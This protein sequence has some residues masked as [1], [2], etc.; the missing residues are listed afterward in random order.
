MAKT[1][2]VSCECTKVHEVPGTDAGKMIACSCGRSVEIPRLSLLRKSAG[3][4]TLSIDLELEHRLRDNSLPE[5]TECLSCSKPTD[6]MAF[7]R[8][9]YESAYK[10]KNDKSSLA[11][12]FI[13]GPLWAMIYR[14]FFQIGKEHG[15][16]L[17]FRLP[18]RL[19]AICQRKT[20]KNQVAELLK[21]VPIYRRFLEKYPLAKITGLLKD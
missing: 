14:Q 8:V 21:K 4:E 9:Q 10:K 3:E 7:S 13:L 15:D 11:F 2:P 6:D 1:Y 12:F 18:L 20:W 17:E 16:N 19:C 5:E